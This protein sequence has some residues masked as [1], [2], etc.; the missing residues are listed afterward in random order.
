MPALGADMLA[1]TL[2]AWRK[3]PGERVRRGEVIA[4]VETEK[5]VIEVE[6]FHDGVVRALLVSPGA[7]VPV[8]TVLASIDE[9]ASAAPGEAPARAAAA[10]PHAPSEPE[11]AL[12]ARSAAGATPSARQLLREHGLDAA[13]VDGTGPHHTL[14]RADVLRAAEGATSPAPT[15]PEPAQAPRVRASPLARQLAKLK[16]LQLESL[17]GSGPGGAILAA[18]V[19]RARSAEAAPTAENA[20]SMRSAIARAMARSKREIPHYYLSHSVDLAAPLAWLAN[21]NAAR[22]VASR[23]LAG[24]LFVRAVALALRKVPELNGHY[25]DAGLRASTDIHVGVAVS[26][27][28]GGLV[29]PAIRYADTLSIDALGAA[30]KYVVSRARAGQLKS[31]ELSSPT[32][33]ITSL[34][35]RGVEGVFPVIIPPQVAMVGFGTISER[36]MAVAGSVCVH[37]AVTVTLAA[38]HRVSDGHR[39]G[40]FLATVAHLLKEPPTP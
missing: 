24:A 26:L 39:G 19:E 30:L 15:L 28:G 37:P 36:P 1:G 32:I 25:T 9:A 8:G 12:H 40:L 17:S 11:P 29:A 23:L 14:T 33:T 20:P 31:S 21:Y 3:Q 35:E 10:E 4:E 18:D 16:G 13:S 27:R 7:R 38:D 34:G 5:G 22:D 2:A 6:C